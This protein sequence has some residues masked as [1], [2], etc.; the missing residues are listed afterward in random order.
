MEP[1]F[2]AFCGVLAGGGAG[3]AA[4]P[5]LLSGPSA[6]PSPGIGSSR[7]K[8]GRLVFRFFLRT[9]RF[10][11]VVGVN[12]VDCSSAIRLPTGADVD[13][14]AAAG[15][16]VAAACALP[17][18]MSPSPAEDGVPSAG[19]TAPEA[20]RKLNPDEEAAPSLSEAPPASGEP[21]AEAGLKKLKPE[22][23]GAPLSPPPPA[24][25]AGLLRKLKPEEPPFWF[26][27]AATSSP[28]EEE[29]TKLNE[30]AGAAVPPAGDPPTARS[31]NIDPPAAGAATSPAP[32]DT[33]KLSNMP[34]PS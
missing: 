4:G 26:P 22:P 21:E 12:D 9:T 18:L 13:T 33:D 29:A 8:P 25:A 30:D 34:P 17:V 28:A 11:C 20:P 1:G 2:F 27:P 15:E 10:C 3:A 16:A 6:S 14:P 5:S 31:P 23:D 19:A 32:P 24:S 7:A